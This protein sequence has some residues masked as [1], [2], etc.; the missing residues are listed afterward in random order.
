MSTDQ[1]VARLLTLHFLV[2]FRHSALVTSTQK[3]KS[4]NRVVLG[5]GTRPLKFT[6]SGKL[7]KIINLCIAC[8]GTAALRAA[9]SCDLAL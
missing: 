3:L 5:V 4:L 7:S 8:Q 9:F 1:L 2:Q 6:A